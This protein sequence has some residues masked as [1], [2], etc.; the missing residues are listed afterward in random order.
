M[1]KI[2]ILF[3]DSPFPLRAGGRIRTWNFINSLKDEFELSILYTKWDTDENER[4]L[5]RPTHLKNMWGVRYDHNAYKKDFTLKG[6]LLRFVK[7]IP[8]EVYRAYNFDYEKKLRQ[9]FQSDSYDFILVR[10]VQQ[11]QYCINLRKDMKGKI[12]FDLDDID[13]R[14][15]D[16][17]MSIKG[18]LNM[19]G[20]FRN[21]LNNYNL[22]R[23]YKGAC[24]MADVCLVS[25]DK[26]KEYVLHK[27]W[28]KNI[29]VVPNAID[30]QQYDIK[31]KE[32][33]ENMILFCGT[34]DYAP[35]VDAIEW[36]T[37]K[38]FP[39]IKARINNVR[40]EIVGRNPG[41]MAK[42]LVNVDSV[43]LYPNA[44]SLNPFYSRAALAIV[45]LRYGAGTRVKILEAGVCRVPVVTTTIGAEG[46]NLSDGEHCLVADKEEDFAEKCLELLQ[47]DKLAQRLATANYH[48]VKQNHD[49]GAISDKIKEIFL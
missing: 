11:A 5:S 20:R 32:P 10:Y 44:E 4:N 8:Y 24:G 36:F 12:I 28:S 42:S 26:N 1:R 7:G 49:M 6:T 21:I 45:P 25:S 41:F 27:N 18:F 31:D 48:F 3:G 17:L 30:E 29:C 34:L 9:I 47:D 39:L 22:K 14:K 43:F 2:L 40:L 46:L 19:N 35:N 23:Y 33:K 13:T 38:I 37:H 16:H 15:N